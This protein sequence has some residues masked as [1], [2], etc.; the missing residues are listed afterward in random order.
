MILYVTE[1]S[2]EPLQSQIVQQIRSKILSGELKSGECI[3]S[4][5]T[6]ARDC[7]VSM[8]TVSRAYAILEQEGLIISHQGKGF[9]ITD[10]SEKGKKN[11]ARNRLQENFELLVTRAYEEGLDHNEIKDVFNDVI[12]RSN[13]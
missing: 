5:R 7:K 12:S 13:D 3:P 4:I 1:L 11:I 9:Y 10:L 6:L 8:I 2:S